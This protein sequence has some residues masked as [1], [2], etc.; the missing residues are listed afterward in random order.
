[1]AKQIRDEIVVYEVSLEDNVRHLF[2]LNTSDYH[3]IKNY[4]T[5]ESLD[6]KYIIVISFNFEKQPSKH[7]YEYFKY[8]ILSPKFEKATVSLGQF[9]LTS[10][11][12]YENYSHNLDNRYAQLKI[13]DGN[14]LAFSINIP[15]MEQSRIT[16]LK[17][18][19]SIFKYLSGVNKQINAQSLTQ[20]KEY[21]TT[22]GYILLT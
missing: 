7:I 22:S 15:V 12:I 6:A 13:D 1:M 3:K 20:L 11:M 4:L 16:S 14:L 8:E 18:M 21:L 2:T 10:N 9:V 17:K 19:V 5:F